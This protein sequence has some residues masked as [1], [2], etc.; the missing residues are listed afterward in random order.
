LANAPVKSRNRISR[1]EQFPES[2][3]WS[4]SLPDLP[5]FSSVKAPSVNGREK[6]SK[7]GR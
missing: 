2:E 3:K 1:I 5:R 6:C 7:N 4:P